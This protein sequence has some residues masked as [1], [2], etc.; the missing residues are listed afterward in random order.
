M[1]ILVAVVLALVPL[2]IAPGFV[3]YF[4][5]TPKLVVLLA[6]TTVALPWLARQR[7]AWR[8]LLSVGAARWF[9]VLVA[10]QVL[11]LALATFWSAH[12]A[13]SFSGSN[14]RR[15]GLVSQ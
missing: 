13:L 14:W 11:S 1:A 9:C 3:F 7:A 6:G 2:L 8:A 15:L 12:P 4:D 10:A 5:V